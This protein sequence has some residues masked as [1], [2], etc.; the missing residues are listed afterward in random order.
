MFDL[1]VL[2]ISLAQQ[3]AGVGLAVEAGDRAVD[4]HYGYHDMSYI[5]RTQPQYNEISGYKPCRKNASNSFSHNDKHEK[6]YQR[7]GKHPF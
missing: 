6:P 5:Q 4:E 2:T 3:V 7:R 1:A